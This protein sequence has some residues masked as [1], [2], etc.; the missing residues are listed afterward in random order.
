MRC[1]YTMR[2]LI[3]G[4]HFHTPETLHL[5][6]VQTRVAGRPSRNFSKI[7]KLYPRIHAAYIPCLSI[8]CP[9]L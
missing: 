3:F 6:A 9:D 2:F 4:G 1:S 5:H 7:T 8:I